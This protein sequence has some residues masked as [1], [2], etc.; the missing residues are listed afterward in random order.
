MDDIFKDVVPQ[1]KSG[2]ARDQLTHIM[3]YKSLVIHAVQL[4][5]STVLYRYFLPMLSEQSIHRIHKG[6]YT[7]ISTMIS[8]NESPFSLEYPDNEDPDF[9]VA[10]GTEHVKKVSEMIPKCLEDCLRHFN[11][12]EAFF[13]IDVKCCGNSEKDDRTV[14][15]LRLVE[16]DKY[17]LALNGLWTD[18]SK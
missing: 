12:V 7:F 1:E 6:M 18:S 9:Y 13:E 8:N 11:G 15:S 3:R 17:S 10:I 2:I 5:L 16:S 14:Q 4:Y